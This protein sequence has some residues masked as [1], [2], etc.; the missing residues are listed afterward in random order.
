MYLIFD[1]NNECTGMIENYNIAVLVAKQTKAKFIKEASNISA[2]GNMSEP[3]WNNVSPDIKR[4]N[5]IGAIIAM[6]IAIVSILVSR[7]AGGTYG[8]AVILFIISFCI[9]FSKQDVFK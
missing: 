6:L 7:S 1:E 5:R 8:I 3:I 9:F 2:M 4:R